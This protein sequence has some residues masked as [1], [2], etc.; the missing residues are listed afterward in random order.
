MRYRLRT[1]VLLTAVG[2]PLL[3][4]LYW[5][6]TWLGGQPIALGMGLLVALFAASVFGLIAWYY[7]LI[8]MISGPNPAQSWRKTKR[9]RFRVR[10]ERYSYGSTWT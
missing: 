5:T 2:P 4:G 8:Y 7:E 3:A 9:R 1:L 10:I 6:A